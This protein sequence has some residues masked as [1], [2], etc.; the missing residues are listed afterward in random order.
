MPP[1]TEDEDDSDSDFDETI[2]L[3][4]PFATD[5]PEFVAVLLKMNPVQISPELSH[6][7]LEILAM[8]FYYRLR[9]TSF[10]VNKQTRHKITMRSS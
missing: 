1:D 8:E 3:R 6:G 5:D 9:N 2:P 4:S 7:E 10:E